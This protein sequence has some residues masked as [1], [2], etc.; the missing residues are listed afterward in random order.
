MPIVRYIQRDESVVDVRGEDGETIMHCAVRSGVAG[1]EGECGGELSCATC[2][3]Y[4]DAGWAARL[5]PRSQDEE[6]LLE[7]V[8]NATEHSRLGCQI[9]LAPD[10]DGLTV[11]VP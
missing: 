9:R 2:H 10:I 6:D 4:I 1:I 7:M 11:H 8:G 3:V 5:R